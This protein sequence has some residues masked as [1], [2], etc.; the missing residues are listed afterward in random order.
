MIRHDGHLGA[1][2]SCLSGNV[3]RTWMASNDFLLKKASNPS[4]PLSKK[5][6]IYSSK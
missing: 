5:T 2:M 3:I 4:I 6:C 1:A